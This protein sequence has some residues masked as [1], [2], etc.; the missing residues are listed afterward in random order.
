[1][2]LL[3]MLLGLACVGRASIITIDGTM[4]LVWQYNLTTSAFTDIT[5]PE[6]DVQLVIND[7]DIVGDSGRYSLSGAQIDDPLF[8][9]MGY[10]ISAW[11]EVD[12]SAFIWNEPSWNATWTT[13]V[14]DL[15]GPDG[16]D[17]RW[18]EFNN[19]PLMT[20]PSS[21]LLLS[22]RPTCSLRHM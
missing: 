19:G 14:E 20:D 11:N 16:G 4:S 1:M 8:E 15:S 17:E 18:M 10:N 2:K 6:M 5:L 21:F 7:N 13:F 22:L 9:L 3:M 12:N